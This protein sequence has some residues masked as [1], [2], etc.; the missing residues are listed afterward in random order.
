MLFSL[1][2][3]KPII[4]VKTIS[5]R[6]LKSVNVEALDAELVNSDLCRNPPDDLDVL[7][8]IYYRTLKDLL[9]KHAPLQTRTIVLRPR[10]PW[11]TDEIRQAKR[12]VG[13]R[14]KDGDDRN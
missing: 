1:Y 4:T 13:G 12:D 8:S 14:K 5:Y 10:V 11:Y 3:N 7:V 2:A 9:E 6:K